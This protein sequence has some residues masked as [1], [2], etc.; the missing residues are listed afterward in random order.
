ML[1]SALDTVAAHIARLGTL[2]AVPAHSRDRIVALGT[3]GAQLLQRRV[4]EMV[5]QEQ[6][7]MLGPAEGVKLVVA[8]LT[9]LQESVPAIH[10]WHQ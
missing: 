7:G 3:M 6:R 10:E 9:H 5:Q 8:I 1:V 2:V 4:V